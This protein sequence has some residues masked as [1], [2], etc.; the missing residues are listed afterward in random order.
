[1]WFMF[2]FTL[3]G[4]LPGYTAT[5]IAAF[6][7]LVGLIGYAWHPNQPCLFLAYFIVWWTGGNL[8]RQYVAEGRVTS[9]RNERRS[10]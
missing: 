1:M 6:I 4:V 8:P 7:S 3:S 9:N 5:I 10:A 2:F